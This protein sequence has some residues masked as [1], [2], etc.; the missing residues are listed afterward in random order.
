[1]GRVAVIATGNAALN[2]RFEDGNW[3]TFSSGAWNQIDGMTALTPGEWHRVRVTGNNV[4]SVDPGLSYDIEVSAAGETTFNSS[5]M[6]LTFFQATVPTTM[7][8]PT[9]FNFN[10]RFGD[11]PGFNVDE[12]T[13]TTFSDITPDLVGDFEPDG[14][15]DIDDIDFYVGN[16][17]AAA[18]GD[19]AQLDLD[20]D[21]MI[22]LADRQ[23]HIETY[24]QTSNG[25]T[26]TFLGD[27]N[28][29]GQVN[30][31]GDALA[32]VTNLGGAVTSYADGDINFDGVVNVL[33]DALIL[34][35]NMGL[36]NEPAE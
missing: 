20:G 27:V 11:N 29:D 1:M 21:E 13:A 18:E 2:I 30:V 4:G 34:V 28:L 36:S 32:L 9:T 35:T 25:Q 31:L 6:G 22:T 23:M 3:D 14:D 12:V 16:I 17:G 10:A 5:A 24:V 19:L 7:D 8:G 15:V 26:G 33:G